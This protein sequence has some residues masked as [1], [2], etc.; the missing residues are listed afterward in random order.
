[1]LASI[2]AFLGDETN[3]AILSWIG[4]GLVVVVGGLW[5][6]FKFFL[7]KKEDEKEKEKEKDASRS[8]ITA[9]HSS[10]AAKTISDSPINIGASSSSKRLK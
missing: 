1:M 9:T 7:P 6:A 4:G 3:R 5:A 8:S 2:W 10:V